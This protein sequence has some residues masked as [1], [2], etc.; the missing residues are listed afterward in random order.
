MAELSEALVTSDLVTVERV[1]HTIGGSLRLFDGCAV[2]ALA[3]ELEEA[4]RDGS[5][6]QAGQVWHRLVPALDALVPAL[7]GFVAKRL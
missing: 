2:V 7:Q 6:E 4:C 1:A 3:T 5:G